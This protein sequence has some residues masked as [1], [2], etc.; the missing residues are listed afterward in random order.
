MDHMKTYAAC[1][2]VWEV[3]CGSVE[4]GAFVEKISESGLFQ[5][6]WLAD[7]LTIGWNVPPVLG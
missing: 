3:L 4:I 7:D 1:G 5:G 6:A 2:G